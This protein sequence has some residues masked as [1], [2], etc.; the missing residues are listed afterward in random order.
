[1]CIRDSFWNEIDMGRFM[2]DIKETRV[3]GLKSIKQEELIAFIQKILYQEK[4]VLEI[5]LVCESHQSENGEILAKRT[6]KNF[7]DTKELQAGLEHYPIIHKWQCCIHLV[8]NVY[9][10]LSQSIGTLVI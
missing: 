7:T 6:E 9:E 5:G 3:E 8:V 1:M 10:L 4:R 2:F